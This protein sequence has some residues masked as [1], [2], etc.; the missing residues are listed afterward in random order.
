MT[1][2]KALI[3]L[4]AFITVRELAAVM[5]V[6]PID[7][8]KE[9]MS[10]GIMANINQDIDF[11]T[12][13]IVAGEMGFEVVSQAEAAAAV[14][15][16]ID[17]KDLLAWRRV[18]AK[19]DAA[20]LQTRPPVV[21]MLGHVDH[22]KT[23]LLDVIRQ[24]N[25][26]AGEAGGITQH[27]G[28]YQVE[29]DGKPVTFLDTPGHA[30]FTSMRARGAQATD[31][32]ILVVAA[33]DGVMPQTREAADHARAAHVPIIVAMNKI[34]LPTANPAKV[35]QQLSEI[36]LIPDEWDGDTMI[37]PV[38]AKER[39][40][41]EDLLEAILLIA[42]DINPRANPQAT[43][44]G[45]VLEAS[46]ERGRGVMA[47]VLVQNGTLRRGDTLL[48]GNHYGRIKS[49]YD[50]RGRQIK[51]ATPSTPVAVS[52]LNDI[53]HAGEQFTVVKTEKEARRLIAEM[54]EDMRQDADGR[55]AGMSLDEF[56]SRLQEGDV[57][58]LN[59][60]VKADVQGSLE[61]IVNSLGKL[62]DEEVSLDI[63]LAAT[64]NVTES[65]VMLASASDAVIL[66]FNVEI[67]PVA[68]AAA[69]SEG[70]QISNYTI[71][72]KLIEDV[73]KAMKGMLDPV[74]EEVLIG[75][76]EVRQVFK[77]RGVGQIAGC[78]MRTGVARR[79]AQARL[80]RNTSLLHSGPVSSLKHLA[81][82][83]REVKAGFE[84]GVSL[85][86]WND[87]RPG[88]YIEF[89]VTQRVENP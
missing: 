9:L 63:L 83:V 51:E 33:D 25:V 10:N 64:G 72:Y 81:E 66:G 31:I 60:I 71:I 24:T 47:T 30:A 68:H 46:I 7:V 32:A 21:T 36:G 8:I 73:E 50:F 16:V 59:L 53:P 85:E 65:D 3:E 77:I 13:A 38:S 27:I 54:Q 76:A 17:E 86:N 28:A 40:G 70:V 56:F 12:A 15:E 78:Y 61:P 80:I 79:N 88:D 43:P 6:S 82:S 45:S 62:G 22:G 20:N 39:L 19:E 4:P 58:T 14:E 48:V 18:L 2:T 42:E 84:F 87:F 37:I 52:G 67:D 55:G 49:M 69:S 34:D 44:S 35:K 29:Q 1:K 57:K 89:F 23:S 74:Y 26:Q 41:I 5:E 75:R 11:D